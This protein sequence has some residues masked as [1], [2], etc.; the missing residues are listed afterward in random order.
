MTFK[1]AVRSY[2]AAV[3]RVERSQQRAY[4]EQIKR[5]KQLEKEQELMDAQEQFKTYKNYINTLYSIHKGGTDKVDWDFMANEA[6]PDLMPN[7]DYNQ[8]V[9]INNLNNYK[10]SFFSKLLGL[11]KNNIQELEKEIKKAKIQDKLTIEDAY[12]KH[13]EWQQVTAMTTGVLNRNKNAYKDAFEYFEP[14]IDLEEFGSKINFV[15]ESNYVIVDFFVHGNELIPK[16]ELNLT[17]TGKLSIKDMPKSRFNE[18]YQDYVCGCALRLAKEVYAYLPVDM[19]IVNAI[20]EL[21]NF[22]TG[23]FEEKTVLSVAMPEANLMRLNFDFIDP[24]DSMENFVHN[25]SFSKTNG[26]KEVDRLNIKDFV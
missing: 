10:P 21:L 14:F 25:M 7:Y 17:K 24:S 5:Y 16:H 19:V 26:F 3:R 15:L 18:Y 20:G 22:K 11:D 2:G 1:G 6:E 12:N 13:L 9:A 4:R 23:H 8:A